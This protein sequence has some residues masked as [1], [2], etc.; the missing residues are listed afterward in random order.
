MNGTPNEYFCRFWYI[1]STQELWSW[2]NLKNMKLAPVILSQFLVKWLV[3]MYPVWE[4]SDDAVVAAPSFKD[5]SSSNVYLLT[6]VKH[7]KINSLRGFSLIQ[8]P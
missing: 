2:G 4:G 7:K 6:N 1:Y 3:L 5:S 8:A